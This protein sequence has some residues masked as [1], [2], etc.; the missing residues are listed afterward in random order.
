MTI[1]DYVP[2]TQAFVI[3]S[4]A[5]ID[6]EVTSLSRNEHSNSTFTIPPPPPPPVRDL[7]APVSNPAI[8][9]TVNKSNLNIS[10]QM[11]PPRPPSSSRPQ[12]TSNDVQEMLLTFSPGPSSLNEDVPQPMEEDNT[13]QEQQR[14]EFTMVSSI[15]STTSIDE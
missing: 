12:V 9:T 4:N 3:E 14:P 15:E 1:N 6:R 7:P 2:S 5:N 13:Q 10:F 8:E 11:A